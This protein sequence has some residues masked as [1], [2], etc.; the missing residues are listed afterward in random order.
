MSEHNKLAFI[1]DDQEEQINSDC[2]LFVSVNTEQISWQNSPMSGVQRKRL[3][4]IGI[5][6]PQITTI[7][8]FA[9]ESYFELHEHDGGEEILVLDG[10]FS[11]VKGDFG[12]GFYVRNPPG[13]THRP[14]SKNGCTILVKLRQ[15]NEGDQLQFAVNTNDS[16]WFSTDTNDVEKLPLHQYKNEQ[17]VMYRFNDNSDAIEFNFFQSSEIYVMEGNIDIFNT[18]YAAGSWLR[19]P[20]N[21]AIKIGSKN[22]ACIWMKIKNCTK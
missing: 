12:P 7:V 11:D 21:T 8:K 14:F 22:E 6:K 9:P 20:A 1:D 16:V 19:Y 18:N 5:K 2:S 3:E 13:T 10:I 4:L 15:F 17:V